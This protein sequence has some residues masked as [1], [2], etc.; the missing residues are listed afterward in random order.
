MNLK[1]YLKDPGNFWSFMI[2]IVP[3]IVLY[4]IPIDKTVPF[5]LFLIMLSLFVGLLWIAL[6]LHFTIKDNE[7]KT[8]IPIIECSHKQC[9]C[10]SNNLL[11]VHSIV[12]FY[13]QDGIHEELI[14]YGYVETINS[15]KAA[16]IV[17]YSCVEKIPDLI[18]YIN[19]NKEKIVVRATLT[20]DELMRISNLFD[21]KGESYE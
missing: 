6:K 16:Q 3:A 20:T 8:S 17:G 1:G 7:Y 10:K 14:G 2:G 13:K 18:S 5:S 11:S 12:S 4:I 21:K 9:I 19:D 15:K